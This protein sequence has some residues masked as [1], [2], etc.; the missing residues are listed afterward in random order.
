MAKKKQIK[1]RRD[2]A[3]ELALRCKKSGQMDDITIAQASHVLKVLRGIVMDEH[4]L[5]ADEFIDLI[6]GI[7]P[8]CCL[9]L[10]LEIGKK[11]K[12]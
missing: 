9:V 8:K 3:R 1:N 7:K 4:A 12:A 10:G 2:L 6:L 11:S 5:P